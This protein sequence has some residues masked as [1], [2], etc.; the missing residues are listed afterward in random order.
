MGLKEA[1]DLLLKNYNFIKKY[2]LKVVGYGFPIFCMSSDVAKMHL[3]KVFEECFNG[4]GKVF[5]NS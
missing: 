3:F 4:V 2:W 1:A 5:L